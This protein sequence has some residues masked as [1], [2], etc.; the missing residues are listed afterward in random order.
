[1]T[2]RTSGL[3]GQC[4]GRIN[5]SSST[6]CV[7]RIGEQQF[8][9][10]CRRE[11]Y[12]RDEFRVIAEPGL[13]IRIGPGP[14]E[15]EF[16]PGMAFFVQRHRGAELAVIV[17]CKVARR[18]T[19]FGRDA[20]RLLG[21]IQELVA[22]ERVIVASEAIPVTRRDSRDVV[23]DGDLHKDTATLRSCVVRGGFLAFKRIHEFLGIQ[24]RHAACAG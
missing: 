2:G 5:Q 22:Q 3:V 19:L 9:A 4:D 13:L 14:V 20:V 8:P 24:G 17:D 1:M 16:A 7:V 18:P 21:K 11:R 10:G 15:Y 6:F 23:V 12:R